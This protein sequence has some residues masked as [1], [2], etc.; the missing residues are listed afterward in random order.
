MSAKLL[1]DIPVVNW[2]YS[3]VLNPDQEI[4]H[5]NLG[6]LLLA[7]D[8]VVAEK[9]LLAAAHLVPDKGGVYFGL[10]L[11]RLN[12]GRIATG[13][14]REHAGGVPWIGRCEMLQIAPQT[15]VV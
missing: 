13:S 2:A 11:A 12:Q 14:Q 7:P 9:H 5:F 10:G 1:I 15:L 8:P 4:A 3:V 6:W